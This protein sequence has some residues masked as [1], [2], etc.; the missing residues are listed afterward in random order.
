MLVL[1]RR[2]GEI[3]RLYTSDGVI[4]VYLN[5]CNQNRAR[6][7]FIAPDNVDIIRVTIVFHKQFLYESILHIKMIII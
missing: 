5:E 2:P 4:E 3:I 6:I 7:G 1:T